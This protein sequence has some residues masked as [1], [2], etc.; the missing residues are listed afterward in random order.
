[1]QSISQAFTAINTL[2]D[3]AQDKG[4]SIRYVP[5]TSRAFSPTIIERVEKTDQYLIVYLSLTALY[6]YNGI[7]PDYFSDEIIRE[8]ANGLKAFLDIFNH[9]QFELMVDIWSKY[10]FFNANTLDAERKT[11]QNMDLIL[12]SLGGSVCNGEEGTPL[13]LRGLRR[14]LLALFQRKEKTP[15]GLIFLLRSFF[16][17][18]QFEIVQHTVSHRNIPQDQR[19]KLG[20]STSVLGSMGNFLCGVKMEDTDGSFSLNIKDLDLKTFNRFLPGGASWEELK[21]LLK[22]YTS[23]QWDCFLSLELRAEE[24]PPWQIG[25]MRLGADSWALSEE[26]Y[27]NAWVSPGKIGGD[28]T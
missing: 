19:T 18:L 26:A 4:L 24:I 11:N 12:L 23:N 14:Y 10:Q 25:S 28:M 5:V 21:H 8:P 6:G 1:M 17:P 27:E 22:V 20:S 16:G 9:R 15:K 7:L 13:F 3:E 2:K